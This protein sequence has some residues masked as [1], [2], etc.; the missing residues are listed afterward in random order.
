MFRDLEVV[1]NATP[2]D[3]LS[4]GPTNP[5]GLGMQMIGKA[6]ALYPKGTGTAEQT[7]TASNYQF[8]YVGPGSG[9]VIKFLIDQGHIANALETSK[10]GISTADPL[11]ISY[12]NW[13]KPW[14]T[15]FANRY[16]DVALL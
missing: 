2:K 16:F 15:P 6:E 11:V 13:S 9:P 10:R 8:L 1:A 7:V 3:Y 12:I 4:H 5:Q 14:E